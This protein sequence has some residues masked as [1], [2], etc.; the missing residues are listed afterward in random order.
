MK[1]QGRWAKEN[2]VSIISLYISSL[3]LLPSFQ[4]DSDAS[5]LLKAEY[6]LVITGSVSIHSSASDSESPVH[7]LVCTS[8]TRPHC[9]LF[10]PFRTQLL[11][12]LFILLLIKLFIYCSVV[13]AYSE[14]YQICDLRRF[15]IG[16]RD[17]GPG[18]ITQELLY[19]RV[20]L[21]YKKAQRKLMT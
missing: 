13:I 1:L 15:S 18:L 5:S 8:V 4:E 3:F 12:P 20:L 16:T 17:Q 2:P 21:K 10:Q 11:G 19:S 9:K 7:A 14:R 6:V